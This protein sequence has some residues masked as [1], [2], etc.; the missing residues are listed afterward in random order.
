MAGA[1][2]GQEEDQGILKTAHL[3]QLRDDAADVPVHAVDLRGV[4]GHLEVHSILLFRAEFIPVRRLWIRRRQGP[5]GID[6]PEFLHFFITPGTQGRPA[7]PVAA[8]VPGDVFVVGVE[9]PVR[10]VVGE[11][12]EEGRVLRVR[13]EHADGPVREG[14][15]RVET[16]CRRRDRP[17][18]L[19]EGAS[20]LRVFSPAQVAEIVHGP[21]DEPV[22]TFK[23]PVH[24]PIR[25]ELAHVPF[26]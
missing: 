7:F 25:A 16:L 6:Q 13:R 22:K 1:V 18:V 5:R 17:V 21:P 9:R 4:H 20:F 26:A 15:R 12:E 19:G 23:A 24:R 8:A 11:I 10:R 2:V 14:V 3:F